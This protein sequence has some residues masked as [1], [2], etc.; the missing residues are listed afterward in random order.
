MKKIHNAKR[1]LILCLL[2]GMSVTLSGCDNP[3]KKLFNKEETTDVS[4]VDT[5]VFETSA[6][7]GSSVTDIISQ[8]KPGTLLQSETSSEE[9]GSD[10][11]D[12]TGGGNPDVYNEIEITIS[13]NKYFYNNHEITYDEFQDI[14]S[15]FDSNTTIKIYDELASDSAYKKITAYLD[16]NEI[17]YIIM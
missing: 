15:Q 14:M 9:I 10:E 13:E 12:S 11:F 3:L 16:E 8:Q 4:E 1:L 2:L 6:E 7:I 5:S 17:P